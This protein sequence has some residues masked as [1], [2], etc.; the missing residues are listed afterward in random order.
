[1]LFLWIAET[2]S[3]S[4]INA[5]FDGT[6]TATSLSMGNVAGTI[7]TFT[8]SGTWTKTAGTNPNP[9][10]I[11]PP[12]PPVPSTNDSDFDKVTLLSHFDGTNLGTNSNF[13]DSS[14]THTITASGDVFQTSFSPFSRPDGEWSVSFDAAESVVVSMPTSFPF[15]TD[16]AASDNFTIEAW[17]F[18]STRPTYRQFDYESPAIFAIGDVYLNFGITATG[19]LMMNSFD[20]SYNRRYLYST[21]DVPLATWTHVAAV[22]STG[23]VLKLY[24][25]GILEATGT[26]YGFENG[27]NGTYDHHIG[28]AKQNTNTGFDGNISN[29]RVVNSSAVYNTSGF[30]P[31]T[32]A[33]TAITDTVLL[34]CQSN[35]FVDNSTSA[36]LLTPYNLNAK[37]SADSPF[38]ATGGYDPAVNG[39]SGYFYNA[40]AAGGNYISSSSS[41]DFAFGTGDFTVD[42]WYYLE[43]NPTWRNL[44]DQSY[45]SLGIAIWIDANRELNFFPSA[46]NGSQCTSNAN[47]WNN[48]WNHVALV[49]DSGVTRLYANGVSGPTYSDSNDYTSTD[50]FKVSSDYNAGFAFEGYVS[51]VRFIKGTAVYTSDFTP[52]TSPT[53]AIT[54]TVLLLNMADGGAIDVSDGKLDMQLFGSARTTTS[55][56]FGTTSLDLPSTADYAFIEDGF[57]TMNGNFTIECWI[58]PTDI[59]AGARNIYDLNRSSDVSAPVL[60]QSGATVYLRMNSIQIHTGDVLTANTW[61]HVA[62]VRNNGVYELFVDGVSTGTYTDAGTEIN[63][64]LWIGRKWFD[65]SENY[66]GFVGYIDEFR[67]SAVARY[68]ENFDV[69]TAAFLEGTV[70]QSTSPGGVLFEASNTWIA[71]AGVTSVSVVCIGGGG[72]GGDSSGVGGGDSYFMN[73]STVKGGGGVT[74]D[75]NFTN[76]RAGGSFAGDG[77]GN[78]GGWGG[79]DYPVSGGGA[80]GYSGDG[81]RIAGYNGSQDG[82]DATLGAGADGAG[83]GGGSGGV[84]TFGSG[85]LGGGGGGVGVYGEGTNGSGGSASIYASIGGVGAGGSSGLSG[86]STSGGS[87]GGGSAGGYGQGWAGTGGGLGYRNKISVTPGASYT[88]VVGTGGTGSGGNNSN[89]ANGAVRIIWGDNR[90]FPSTNAGPSDALPGGAAE[91]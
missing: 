77:G 61:H 74:L 87:Y 41:S 20:A 85:S 35:R 58:N 19:K 49:R 82:N 27:R 9:T 46:S 66:T 26:W 4:Q 76:S 80:G 64:N 6:A 30:T 8:S 81:G 39:A 43:D 32:S 84:G 24:I 16:T 67:I 12:A 89:G 28:R 11:V 57:P 38:V 47:L 2:Y 88:V 86:S 50:G 63:S 34:A 70:T 71:P 10:P 55:S 22:V 21:N 7:I 53:T 14:Y 75:E 23:A 44:I 25:N 33:L 79:G 31:P 65:S 62:L 40:N 29:L 60:L 37:I 59:S 48:E 54:N 45:N 78:G 15:S 3:T 42:L 83:G 18:Q 51:N 36:R 73:T 68:V 69:P 90:A 17:V 52:P 72:F 5:D 91:T 13:T 56:K 1:M